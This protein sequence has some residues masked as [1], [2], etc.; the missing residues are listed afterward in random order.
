MSE[1]EKI[2][3]LSNTWGILT[4]ALGYLARLYFK[5][6]GIKGTTFGACK[7]YRYGP[8]WVMISIGTTV[9]ISPKSPHSVIVHEIG[10][11]L[12]NAKLGILYPFI[13]GIPSFIRCG[14]YY[15]LDL[16]RVTPKRAYSAAWFEAQATKMGAEYIVRNG[17]D[18][19]SLRGG[20]E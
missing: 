6:I 1:T 2:V 8:R 19:K 12:Q 9:V 14:Y 4:T 15:F 11:T 5:I 13:V 17:L 10:H 18:I 7:V 20:D 16:I 3:K